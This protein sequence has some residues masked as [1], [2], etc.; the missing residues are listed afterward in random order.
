MFWCSCV[1]HRVLRGYHGVALNCNTQFLAKVG[2]GMY[3]S[4]KG[5][6]E[7]CVMIHVVLQSF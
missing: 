5:H 2:P 7:W 1:L 3:E 6:G 4:T